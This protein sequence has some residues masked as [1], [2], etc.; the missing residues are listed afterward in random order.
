MIILKIKAVLT[1]NAGGGIHYNYPAEYDPEKIT[2]LC[3]EHVGDKGAVVD[4]GTVDEYL[5]GVVSD[6]DAVQFL[7]SDQ[8]TQM[9]KE[10]A[11]I[12][13]RQWRPQVEKILDQTKVLSVLSKYVR[14]DNLSPDDHRAIDPDDLTPG[15]NKSE[16]FDNLLNRHI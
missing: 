16:L 10:E 9:S 4:R 2:V 5:I 13:G 12:Q 8:I 1:P 11:Q 15:I 14:G 6:E 3:Y 7:E